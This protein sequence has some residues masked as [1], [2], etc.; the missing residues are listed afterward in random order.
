MPTCLLNTRGTI[1]YVLS[2]ISLALV[3]TYLS[4]LTFDREAGGAS[5]GHAGGFFSDAR[6]LL[7]R[8]YDLQL[9]LFLNGTD[10]HR[11][12]CSR[13]LYVYTT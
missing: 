11:R 4:I 6:T 8:D 5:T 1:A 3:S 9:N 7:V 2:S 12:W 13:E 10:V